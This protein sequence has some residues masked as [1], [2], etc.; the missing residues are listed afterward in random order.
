MC[1]PRCKP[2]RI[3]LIF[4]CELF[5]QF[6]ARNPGTVSL[7]PGASGTNRVASRPRHVSRMTEQPEVQW[8][9]AAVR[10]RLAYVSGTGLCWRCSCLFMLVRE[11]N[12][13]PRWVERTPMQG[14]EQR[15]RHSV[16][17]STAARLQNDRVMS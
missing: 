15:M 9:P 10:L 7:D 17:G 6:W 16:H 1:Q 11:V 5:L 14:N 8:I 3:I 13:C 4:V 2:L 12:G